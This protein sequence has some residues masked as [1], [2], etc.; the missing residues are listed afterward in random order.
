MFVRMSVCVF[1]WFCTVLMFIYEISSVSD[2]FL[3]GSTQEM[4]EVM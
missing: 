4:T 1:P 2:S 3:T